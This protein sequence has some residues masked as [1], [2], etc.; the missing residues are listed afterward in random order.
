ME[1]KDS[2]CNQYETLLILLVIYLFYM[3]I[4]IYYIIYICHPVLMSQADSKQYT[5]TSRKNYLTVVHRGHRMDAV[6][7]H[8]NFSYNQFGTAYFIFL[9]YIITLFIFTI[10]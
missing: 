2:A 9:R 1:A 8:F 10:I 7:L 3:S 5:R 6:Q 4:I